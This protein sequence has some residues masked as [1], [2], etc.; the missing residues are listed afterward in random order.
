MDN[1]MVNLAHRIQMQV[2]Q[3]RERVI[4]KMLKAQGV[5]QDNPNKE[6]GLSENSP[7]LA[8][9]RPADPVEYYNGR[10]RKYGY[11]LVLEVCGGSENIHLAKRVSTAQC[12]YDVH[13]QHVIK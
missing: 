6:L 7:K 8:E 1:N 13:Y 4:E 11:F 9:C 3:N 12:H 2:F 10:L 5:E